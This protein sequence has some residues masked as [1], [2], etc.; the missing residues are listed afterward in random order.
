MTQKL[1]FYKMSRKNLRQYVLSHRE[2][3]EALRIY[4]KRL[5][6]ESGVTRHS[7][8]LNGEDMKQLG[9]LIENTIARTP[10]T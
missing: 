5:R 9:K 3:A 7:G 1:D 8:G 2:D 6:L 10:D 4:M